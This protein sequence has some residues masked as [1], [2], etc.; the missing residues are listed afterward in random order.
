MDATTL[1]RY[2]RRVCRV[3]AGLPLS[4]RTQS[5]FLVVDSTGTRVR[6]TDPKDHSGHKHHKR[7]K[8]QIIVNSE[9]KI[10]AVS[11][12][13]AG[14]VHDKTIWNYSYD[15]SEPV[16]DRVV[17]GDK[18]Y[19]GGKAEGSTLFRPLK[20]NE[21][22]YKENKEESKRF[23]R[24]LSKARVVVEHTFAQMKVFRVLNNTFPFPPNQYG[25]CF[26]AIA[27]IHNANLAVF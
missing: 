12:A 16:L 3:L 18:A 6:S 20:R 14:S 15:A 19:A 9:R 5:G 27:I 1:H 11:S 25:Q 17:L 22:E 8:C 4:Q 10:V 13:F 7:R 26:R 24:E 23:N 2:V 21:T